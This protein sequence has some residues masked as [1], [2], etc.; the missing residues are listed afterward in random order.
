VQEVRDKM[1]FLRLSGKKHFR[2]TLSARV[3]RGGVW[4]DLGIVAHPEEPNP[5][6]RFLK[7]HILGYHFATVLT[8]VGEEWIVDKLDEAV[9]TKPDWLHWGT[10]S[11]T[12]SKSATGLFTPGSEARVQGTVSQPVADKLRVVGTLT[13]DAAKTITNAG[14]FTASTGGT[15][16]I[17]GDHAGQALGS[18]DKIEYTG[19]LEAT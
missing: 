19:D 18:G 5:I 1:R 2:A 11:G 9:Q 6:L 17:F 3:C 13:A 14:T 16:V 15:L 8:Q 7:R 12:A 4:R 10:G